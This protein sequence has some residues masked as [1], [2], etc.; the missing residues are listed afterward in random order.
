[1]YDSLSMV[2]AHH[3]RS[4][5]QVAC[6]PE[7]ALKLRL[8]PEVMKLLITRPQNVDRNRTLIF[9]GGTEIEKSDQWRNYLAK[10]PTL[11]RTA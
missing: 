6:A 1:V 8:D 5:A 7:T 4:G 10:N 2:V 11:W 9:A 3:I